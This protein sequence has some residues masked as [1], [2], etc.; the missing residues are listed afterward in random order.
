M[1]IFH[2]SGLPSDDVNLS[3]DI[4]VETL[5]V[6]EYIDIH[7]ASGERSTRDTGSVKFL[8]ENRIVQLQG[9]NYTVNAENGGD[10]RIGG[11]DTYFYYDQSSDNIGLGNTT[12]P[13]SKLHVKSNDV[14]VDHKVENTN[15]SGSS[16]VT[17]KTPSQDC[18]I[19]NEESGTLSITNEGGT[20]TGRTLFVQRDDGYFQWNT[21]PDTV[22]V[23]KMFL[24]SNGRLGL[25]DNN[26]NP[27][28]TLD[29]GDGNLVVT[30]SVGDNRLTLTE[31]KISCTNE[32][33][34]SSKTLHIENKLNVDNEVISEVIRG[35]TVNS[36]EKII[37]R[38]SENDQNF[39]KLNYNSTDGFEFYFYNRT[40]LS[41]I[42]T[43]TCNSLTQ[44]SDDRCKHNE[45]AVNNALDTINKLKLYKYD[46]T[47][48]MLNDN[49]N[50]S[51]SIETTKEVGFIAQ[52]VNQIP[53]LSFL[54]T[55]GYTKDV[56]GDKK[57]QPFSLNYQGLNNFAIQAIQEL[58][59]IVKEQ[60][61]QI[62]ALLNK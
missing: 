40:S 34:T 61:E 60:Q 59:S 19:K 31:N 51:L 39:A 52:D 54:V 62:N 21:R 49:F 56:D 14:S 43:V 10:I 44:T 37:F 26:Y 41:G 38:R 11:L 47:G 33:G 12:S 3:D 58:H 6:N 30:D 7:G 27:E 22:D 1:S 24:T 4:E 16:S 5:K 29:I 28:A 8:D 13:T 48:E 15:S 20:S 35:K 23:A 53:E 45:E 17:I 25:G 57:E 55:E 18:S 50:G 2:E 9:N 46:K 32:L 36:D 42:T